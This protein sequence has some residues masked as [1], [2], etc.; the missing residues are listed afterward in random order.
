MYPEQMEEVLDELVWH[1][2]KT[3]NDKGIDPHDAALIM[4]RIGDFALSGQFS[5][6][7]ENFEYEKDDPGFKEFVKDVININGW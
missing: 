5:D 2:M 1:T 3:L 6:F 7:Y 4:Q